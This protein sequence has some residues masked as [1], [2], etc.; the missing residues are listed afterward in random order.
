MRDPRTLRRAVALLG[1]FAILAAACGPTTGPTGGQTGPADQPQK[2]GRVIEGSFSD[3]RTLQPIL[4]AD[5]PSSYVSGMLYDGLI[6]ADAKSGEP[7]PNMAT[8]T[9]APGGKSFT[10][11]I[12]NNVN[13]TDGKPVVA[14][15]YITGVKA[16]AKSKKTVR[17]SLMNGIAGFQDYVDGKS[18]TIAGIKVDAANPKKFTVELSAIRCDGLLDFTSYTLPAHVFGKYLTATSADAIDTAPENDNPTVFNGPFKFKEWRK[19]DQ[20]ILTRN[21]SY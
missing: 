16:V 9:A 3:I 21:D 14:D 11:E 15:D 19:G 6:T 12:K 2:G 4:V 7:K 8:F 13:W 20:V 17:K 1:T 18:D 10:F 5:T